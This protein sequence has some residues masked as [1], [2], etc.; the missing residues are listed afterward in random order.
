MTWASSYRKAAFYTKV[1]L[2]CHLQNGPPCF[3]VWYRST[4]TAG[5]AGLRPVGKF[6]LHSGVGLWF[7]WDVHE[8]RQPPGCG[9]RLVQ[10][11]MNHHVFII[12]KRHFGGNGTKSLLQRPPVPEWKL[13]VIVLQAVSP[14]PEGKRSASPAWGWLQGCRGLVISAEGTA[15]S[16]KSVAVVRVSALRPLLASF[17]YSKVFNSRLNDSLFLLLLHLSIS[18][19]MYSFSTHPFSV[20]GMTI[21]WLLETVN[22]QHCHPRPRFLSSLRWTPGFDPD[23]A[24]K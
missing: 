14:T 18:L 1:V 9:G 13:K 4:V 16:K 2:I 19:F 5:N 24:V 22:P 23:V 3:P 6:M 10:D 8:K 12:W 15:V 17:T 21:V 20:C 11:Q 7:R